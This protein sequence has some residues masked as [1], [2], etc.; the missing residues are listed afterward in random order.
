MFRPS[1]KPTAFVISILRDSEQYFPALRETLKS[2][3]TIVEIAAGAIIEN[4]SVDFTKNLA[5]TLHPNIKRYSLDGLNA[6]AQRTIRLEICRNFARKIFLNYYEKR[7]VSYV[8]VID[9]LDS[10]ACRGLIGV[11]SVF[12]FFDKNPR[13]GGIF[14]NQDGGYYDLWA[15]RPHSKMLRSDPCEGDL[16]HDY[17]KLTRGE[18][19]IHGTE[20]YRNT[21]GEKFFRERQVTIDASSEPISVD[22]AF[23]GLGIYRASAYAD[24]PF[25]YLGYTINARIESNNVTFY[26]FQLCEHVPFHIGL[27]AMGMELK[28]I[29]SLINMKI[30]DLEFYP[31]SVGGM[32]F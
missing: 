2:I 18:N 29:P 6:I 31:D 14:P 1:A 17:F 25:P 23:G 30:N 21:Q 10:G 7:K 22:S 24:C 26:R 19:W 32:V 13:L 16:W 15:L 4:D 3:E 9:A 20:E 11:E 5:E 12:D 8:V 27:R 28:I